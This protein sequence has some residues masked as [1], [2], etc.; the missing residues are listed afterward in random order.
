[1]S[2]NDRYKNS[3]RNCRASKQ[4]SRNISKADVI[5]YIVYPTL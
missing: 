3:G 2:W 1:M 4:V 5:A